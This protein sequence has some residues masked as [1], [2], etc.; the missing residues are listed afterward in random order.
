MRTAYRTML[1]TALV[2]LVATGIAVVATPQ[3]A[4]ALPSGCTHTYV[5]SERGTDGHRGN[6]SPATVPDSSAEIACVPG[7]RTVTLSSFRTVNQLHVDGGSLVDVT[8][9]WL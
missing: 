3:G 8:T 6:W 4:T 5:R 9:E 1:R 7:G 2:A